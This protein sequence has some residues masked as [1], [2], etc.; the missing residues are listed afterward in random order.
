MD[1]SLALSGFSNIGHDVGGFAGNPPDEEL[2]I[3]WLWNGIFTPRLCIHSWRPEG[4]PENSPWMLPKLLPLVRRRKE[5]RE[6][7][8]R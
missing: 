1:T 3:R 4:Q 7:Q 6:F 2:F 8:V 5:P